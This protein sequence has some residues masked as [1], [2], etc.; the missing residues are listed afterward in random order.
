MRNAAKSIE[1]NPLRTVCFFQSQADYKAEQER[2]K[3]LTLDYYL[4]SDLD[5]PR[6]EIVLG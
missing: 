1:V 5:D 6:W 4:N 3:K 2:Q